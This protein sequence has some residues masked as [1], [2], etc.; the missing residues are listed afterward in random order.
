M[1]IFFIGTGIY[2]FNSVSP[3][4]SQPNNGLVSLIFTTNRNPE[5]LIGVGAQTF[6]ATVSTV[7]NTIKYRDG[8]TAWC[9]A[10]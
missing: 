7:I 9:T 3:V 10:M 8:A 1:S 4:G 2:I 6:Y 5:T